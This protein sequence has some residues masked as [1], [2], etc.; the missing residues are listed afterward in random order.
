[1]Y[2]LTGAVREIGIAENN[3]GK[4]INGRPK[5]ERRNKITAII[6]FSG[7][8]YITDDRR[9]VSKYKGKTSMS[10]NREGMRGQ[11]VREKEEMRLRQLGFRTV[12]ISV[13]IAGSNVFQHS[14]PIMR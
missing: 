4:N 14:A 12:A 6:N 10:G 11:K 8:Y 3:E 7:E 13:G 5:T 1:M 9:W 2:R